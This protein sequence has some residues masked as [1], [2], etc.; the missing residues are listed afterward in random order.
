[1]KFIVFSTSYDENSGGV[2]IL[3]KLCSIINQ[4]GFECYLYPYFENLQ[5][6]KFN[7]LNV[8]YV[9]LKSLVRDRLVNYKTNTEFQTPIFNGDIND[10]K[11]DNYV[12]IYP[13]I[14]FGN[15]L[16]AKNVVRWFLHKPGF[17]TGNVFYGEGEFYVDYNNFADGFNYSGS[18]VSKNR[19]NIT[20]SQLGIYNLQGALPYESRVGSAYCLRKGKH[21]KIVHD[22][23][24]SVLIDDKSHIEIAQIFKRVKCFYS[25][26]TYTNYSQFAALCGADSIIIPDSGVSENEWHPNIENRYGL[27]YGVENLAFAR[28]TKD[29]VLNSVL[30]TQNDELNMVRR[31]V[32]DVSVFFKSRV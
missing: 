27:A 26:D 24:D 22:L 25:Y 11:G 6:N 15:P 17:H 3:H 13:E 16:N 2:I 5:V 14:V 23:S 8:A 32:E 12:V 31:F 7:L 1:M 19:L 4:L 10:L 18:V 20:H 21:K 30:K 29:K 28:S 9:L